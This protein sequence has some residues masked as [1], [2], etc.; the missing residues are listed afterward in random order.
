MFS[1]AFTEKDQ[2]WNTTEDLE[3]RII[4]YGP[5]VMLMEWHF[6]KEGYVIPLH[7]HYHTQVSYVTKGSVRGIMADGSE[8]ILKAGEAVYFAPNEVHSVITLEPDTFVM[9]VFNP[10]RLDHLEKHSKR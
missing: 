4:C 5:E 3:S 8:Q 10:V 1:K 9:D 6:F 7:D 2:L